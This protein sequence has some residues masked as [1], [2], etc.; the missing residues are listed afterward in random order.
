MKYLTKRRI[1][2]KMKQQ[3]AACRILWID[4]AKVIGIWL[5]TLGHLKINIEIIT[6]IYSFHMP[7]FFFISGYLE[8]DKKLIETIKGGIR[9]LIIPYILLYTLSFLAWVPSRILWHRELFENNPVIEILLLKPFLGMLIGVGYDTDYSTM[10][11]VPLWFLVGLFFVKIIH[12]IAIK[13]VK[14]NKKI[15]ILIN[16]FIILC[17][18]LI[19]RL[20][21]DLWF[22]IDSAFLAYPFFSL[23]YFFKVTAPKFIEKYFIE[24]KAKNVLYKFFLST[25]VFFIIIFLC[26]INGRID[27]NI[28]NYGRNIILF[29]I[30]AILGVFMVINISTIFIKENILIKTISNGT[31]LILAYHGYASAPI[32]RLIG[33]Y[34]KELNIFIA[35]PVSLV[36]TLIM[37]FPIIIA[38]KYF[39]IIM[40]RRK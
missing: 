35:I 22:S 17:I 15:Y 8:K 32:I 24:N 31:I 26:K 21:I 1:S 37:I 25:I 13:L 18:L 40:G 36:S 38:K 27:I 16:V 33:M 29:Y 12:S 3:T 11:N 20:T 9:N 7:L 39:S 34:A 5:V 2:D 19:K 6:L 30:T 28:F 23:G 14:T 4:F 10:M